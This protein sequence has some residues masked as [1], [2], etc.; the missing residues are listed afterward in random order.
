METD[1]PGP[2]YLS[3]TP[4]GEKLVTVGMN[5]AIRVFTTGSDEEP[6]TIDDCSDSNTAVAAAVCHRLRDRYTWA[7]KI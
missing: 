4:N 1:E 2:T 7:D 5:N 3:Y 6:T